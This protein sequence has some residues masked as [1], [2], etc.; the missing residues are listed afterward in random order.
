LLFLIRIAV[1]WI[2]QPRSGVA[3]VELVNDKNIIKVVAHKN[4]EI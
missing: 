1:T 4:K 3:T 2:I